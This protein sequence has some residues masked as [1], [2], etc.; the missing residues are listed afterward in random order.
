M[1]LLEFMSS[2]LYA[3][4]SLFIAMLSFYLFSFSSG[5]LVVTTGIALDDK[6]KEGW[7]QSKWFFFSIFL[8][9]VGFGYLLL[10]VVQISWVLL[11]I[12]N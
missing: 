3:S 4:V 9:A 11:T 8:V 12:G 1:S 7:L 10:G 5:K 6:N 2:P